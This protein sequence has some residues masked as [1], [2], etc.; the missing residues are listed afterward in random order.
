MKKERGRDVVS[1]REGGKR[2]ERGEGGRNGEDGGGGGGE[3]GD[4]VRRAKGT[5][6]MC[7]GLTDLPTH[8]SSVAAG[9]QPLG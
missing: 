5:V 2:E 6:R 1:G 4:G 7:P 9:R 3:A 8:L